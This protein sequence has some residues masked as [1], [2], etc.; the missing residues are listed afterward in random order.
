MKIKS[1]DFRCSE[2]RGYI[3]AIGPSEKGSSG[4]GSGAF[5]TKVEDQS[6]SKSEDFRKR[7]CLNPLYFPSLKPSQAHQET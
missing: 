1:K 7:V 6:A 5:T 3:A 2:N 4:L